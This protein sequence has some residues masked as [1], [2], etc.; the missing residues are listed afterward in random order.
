MEHHMKTLEFLKNT[1]NLSV[2]LI[3]CAVSTIP[4]QKSVCWRDSPGWTHETKNTF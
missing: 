4:K 2:E 1:M 3:F